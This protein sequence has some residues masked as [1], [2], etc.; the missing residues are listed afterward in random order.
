MRKRVQ[1]SRYVSNDSAK[2]MEFEGVESSGNS[3][4]IPRSICAEPVCDPV[5][6]LYSHLMKRRDTGMKITVKF[7][8]MITPKN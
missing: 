8:F 3:Q 4:R 7:T 5:E 1:D 6:V 2:H